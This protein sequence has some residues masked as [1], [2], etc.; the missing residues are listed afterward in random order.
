M[1]RYTVKPPNGLTSIGSKYG[2]IQDVIDIPSELFRLF[3]KLG[4]CEDTGLEPYEITYRKPPNGWIPVE[5]RLPELE[6]MV[7]AYI[8]RND[9]EDEWRT[10]Q[11]YKYTDYWIGTGNL[12]EVVA[13]MPLPEPYRPEN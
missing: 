12:F 9:V 2:V 6:T 4:A 7:L 10:Y 1:K 8:K 13:W 3:D 5:E 11:V